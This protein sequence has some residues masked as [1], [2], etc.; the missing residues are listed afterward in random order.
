MNPDTPRASGPPSVP[1]GRR[2]WLALG[3]VGG[4]FAIAPPLWR[5][6]RAPRA[7][8]AIKLHAAPRPLPAPQFADGAGRALTLNDFRG[9]VVLLNV[10]ATW[11]A[12]CR[13]EM[14]TL[15]RLQ[16]LLGGPDFEVLALSI[17]QTGLAVV[18]PF[19]DRIGI[20]HL[21]P[22][23][24]P[25]GAAMSALAVAGVPLTLLID[26][27]GHEIG[28][29]LGPAV[30]DAPA[31]VGWLRGRIEEAARTSTSVFRSTEITSVDWGRDFRL[32][33]HHG[34]PRSLR[35]FGG[36][37]VMLFFGFTHCRDVCPPTMAD[38]ARLVRRLGADGA[39]V[40]VLFMTV[41]PQRDTAPAL[42]R[43]ATAFLPDFLGLRGDP[44]ETAAMA[45]EFKF[46]HA[47]HAP[48][49]RGDYAVDHGSAIYVYGPQ[50][51][52]R[53]LMSGPRDVEVMAA[54]VAR[55]LAE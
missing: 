2:T 17:D 18:Q 7:A 23:L 31:L 14:P 6:L 24:D 20:R 11:C 27:D 49:A 50:G 53:P 28:R 47:A 36:K 22:Y 32:T 26:R 5:A 19:F 34:R 41:D 21:R 44:T 37:M 55:L 43:Y 25:A 1:G 51:R 52:R 40:Q 12:P 45:R 4:L 35:D 54:D 42:A 16:G 15:D 33:D 8:A 48:D 10:W 38:L 13:E 29:K 9:R 3:L 30:W 46:F 39:G